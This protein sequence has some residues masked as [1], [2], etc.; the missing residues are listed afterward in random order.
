MGKPAWY[1]RVCQRAGCLEPAFVWYKYFDGPAHS[2]C[3]AHWLQRESLPDKQK[4]ASEV[5]YVGDQT[6]PARKGKR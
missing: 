1:S 3:F 6:K 5:V 2:L 4:W